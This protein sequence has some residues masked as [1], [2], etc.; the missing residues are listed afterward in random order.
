MP[1][2][3][4]CGCGVPTWQHMEGMMCRREGKVAARKHFSLPCRYLPQ[5]KHVVSDRTSLSITTLCAAPTRIHER[6]QS[7]LNCNHAIFRGIL[8]LL[9]R[10]MEHCFRLAMRSCIES[11][12]LYVE[13]F[14][15]TTQLDPFLAKSQPRPYIANRHSGD[16]APPV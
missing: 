10:F 2:Y 15:P 9:S 13:L 7:A 11:I 14:P 3:A 5:H 6:A 12:R 16:N 4:C 1:Q 8:R